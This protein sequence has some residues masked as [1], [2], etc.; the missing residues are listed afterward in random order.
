[1]AA[2]FHHY[3]WYCQNAALI[4]GWEIWIDRISLEIRR[5]SCSQYRCGGDG[6]SVSWSGHERRAAPAACRTMKEDSRFS[7]GYKERKVK[8]Q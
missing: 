7:G 8:R 3:C 6:V 2:A 1:M 5:C 4:D